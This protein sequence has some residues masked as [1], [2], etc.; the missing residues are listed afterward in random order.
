VGQSMTTLHGLMDK[1]QHLVQPAALHDH[2][3]A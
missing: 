3:G 1:L 2:A